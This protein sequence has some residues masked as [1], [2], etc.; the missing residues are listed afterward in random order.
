MGINLKIHHLLSLSDICMPNLN[1][2]LQDPEFTYYY[3]TELT[4]SVIW[5]RRWTHCV[6]TVH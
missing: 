3:Q 5:L 4:S 1:S 6:C 2:V